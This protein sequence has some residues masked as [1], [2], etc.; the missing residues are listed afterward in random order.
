MSIKRTRIPNVPPVFTGA[1]VIRSTDQ[2]IPDATDTAVIFDTE[3]YDFGGLWAGG[4]PT[5]L[6]M[7]TAGIY[8]VGA[9]VAFDQPVDPIQFEMIIRLN[10][11]DD[12]AFQIMYFSAT[13]NPRNGIS[14]DFLFAA[15]DY[16]ELIVFQ[17]NV[18]NLD[19]DL[20]ERNPYAPAM[21]A[22]KVSY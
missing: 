7:P 17:S 14:T 20:Q 3:V 5:R 10:A 11:T 19:A 21:W 1:R 13:D 4:A 2:A 12:V 16:I 18:G 8:H 15:A 9:M 6:T 22:H